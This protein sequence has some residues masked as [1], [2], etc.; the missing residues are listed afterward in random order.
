MTERE[1]MEQ[2]AIMQLRWPQSKISDEAADLWFRDLG[3]FEVEHVEAAITALYRDGRE[4]VPN[5]AQIRNKLIE[6]R[7]DL[8]DHGEAYALAMKAASS[9]GFANGLE[10]LR[11][12]S[13]I[14]ADAAERYGWRD[15]CLNGDSDEGTRRAQ[16]RDIYKNAA[17]RAERDER[18]LGIEAAGLRGL[19]SGG[20]KRFGD[21]AK[22]LPQEIA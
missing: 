3:E 18:Y 21:I 16:F 7:T 6:L 12:E 8:P 17:K 14:V 10:W 19:P 11:E 4:W 5:G 9:H 1:W 15:F 13:A 2:L 22:Q 20:P